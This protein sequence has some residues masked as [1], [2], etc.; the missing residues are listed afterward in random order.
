MS[1]LRI[2]QIYANEYARTFCEDFLAG[3]APRYVFGTNEFAASI[4]EANDLAGFIDDFS[5]ASTFMGRPIVAIDSVPEDALVVSA[6]TIGKPIRAEQRL[7]QFAFRSLDYFA[8]CRHSGQQLE[9]IW[10]WRGFEA[11]F[12]A[13]RDR[14]EWVYQQLADA[15]SRNQFHNILNFRH[16]YDLN[17]MRGFSPIEDKQYFED[18]LPLRE[19]GEVFVD[20]GAYDGYTSEVFVSKC[21]GYA[22]IHLFEPEQENMKAARARL[23]D[24]SNIH[25]HL[26]GLSNDKATLKF[27]TSGPSSSIS[28][29]GDISIEVDRLDSVVEGLVTFLKMDVEGAESLALAGAEETIQKNKPVMA[30]AVYHKADDFWRIP[31]QVLSICPDYKIYLRHYTEGFAETVMFFIPA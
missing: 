7:R 25:Y 5:G 20:V 4:G 19:Q 11:D 13:N 26:L 29:A 21:P 31:Q 2:A 9:E 23:G 3:T 24:H 12:A 8:F 27:S 16:S 22:G 1:K 28:D 14:Y 17:Y 6:V 30:I 18:F 10:Y 15:T